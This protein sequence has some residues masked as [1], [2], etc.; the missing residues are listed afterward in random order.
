MIRVIDE[1]RWARA[2]WIAAGLL[3]F[4]ALALAGWLDFEA[5]PSEGAASPNGAILCGA[6]SLAILASIRRRDSR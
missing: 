3:A 6:L 2:R 1:R 4:A 5:Q